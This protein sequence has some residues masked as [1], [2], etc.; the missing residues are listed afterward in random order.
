MILPILLSGML[1]YYHFSGLQLV[2]SK[3]RLIEEAGRTE[4]LEV[5]TALSQSKGGTVLRPGFKELT[6]ASQT[7]KGRDY[8]SGQTAELAGLLRPVGDRE[9]TL[10]RLKMTCCASDAVPLKVRIYAP[11]ELEHYGL[12]GGKGVVVRGQIEFRK[13][14]GSQEYL[15]IMVAQDVKAADLGSDVYDQSR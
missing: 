4:D 8:W 11:E 15:P 13:V 2:Y 1:L 5:N 6:D 9:F 10:F 7:A 12:E 3:T 14:K